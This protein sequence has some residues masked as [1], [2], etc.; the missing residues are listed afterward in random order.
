MDTRTQYIESVVVGLVVGVL[1]IF[2]QSYL[3]EN[4]NFMANVVTIWVVP[5]FLVSYATEAD[6]GHAILLSII[7]FMASVLG[8][9]AVGLPMGLVPLTYQALLWLVMGALAGSL[10]GVAAFYANYATDAAR[11]A[12]LSIV[13][14]F[15]LS[16][17]LG[18]LIVWE[19]NAATL[20]AT[21][22]S[23]CI[24]IALYLVINQRESGHWKNILGLVVLT[25]G[26]VLVRAMLTV[27]FA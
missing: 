4:L 2:G 27:L 1:T 6:M 15:F 8:Y 14:A 26:F 21:S 5:A 3:P 24:G 19:Q 23:V 11:Y 7:C 17:A 13:P 12:A 25:A 10:F 16:E 18:K 20:P 22:I 9:Y